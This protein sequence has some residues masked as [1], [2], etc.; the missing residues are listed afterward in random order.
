M[1]QLGMIVDSGKESTMGVLDIWYYLRGVRKNR[2][3]KAV[4]KVRGSV[5]EYFAC[6]RFLWMAR[7]CG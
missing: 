7:L 4:L 1:G 3:T 2:N 6:Q 5:L